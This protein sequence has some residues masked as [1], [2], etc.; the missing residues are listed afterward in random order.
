MYFD[1]N[2]AGQPS[3]RDGTTCMD[4][5]AQA[6]PTHTDMLIHPKMIQAEIRMHRHT[7]LG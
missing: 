5:H 4:I 1:H 3:R 7:M 2:V 6:L